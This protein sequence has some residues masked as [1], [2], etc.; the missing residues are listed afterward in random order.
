MLP[1]EVIVANLTSSQRSRNF[2]LRF[3]PLV[4]RATRIRSEKAVEITND[5][6]AFVMCEV[7]EGPQ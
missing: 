2:H 1:S 5:S 7:R 3:N 4:R 6:E